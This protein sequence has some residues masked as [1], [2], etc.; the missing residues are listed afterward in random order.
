LANNS[1]SAYFLERVPINTPGFSHYADF[2][3][4]AVILVFTGEIQDITILGFTLTF[5]SF[6]SVAL[7]FGVKESAI[8]NNIFT[9]VNVLVVVCVIG[10]GLW[11]VNL[12]NWQIAPD[13]VPTGFGTGGFAPYGMAGILKGAAICFY[14][15]IGFDVIA[16]AGEEA[17]NPKRSI[18]ISIVVSLTVIF[19]AYFGISSVLTMMLPYFEQNEHSPLPYAFKHYGWHLAEYFITVGAIFGLLASLMGSMFPLPRIIY[20]MASDGLLYSV[21]G[22]VNKR[23]STP[24]YGTFISGVATGTLATFFNLSQLVA[25]MSIGTLLAYSMVAVCVLI[26]RYEVNP[27]DDMEELAPIRDAKLMIRKTFGSSHQKPDNISSSIATGSIIVFCSACILF[28][29]V[30]KFMIAD[31]ASGEWPA[32]LLMTLAVLAGCIS[33]VT[34]SFQPKSTVQLPFQVPLAPWIPCLSILTNVYL[35]MELD[36]MTWIR[37]AVWIGLGL[38]VYFTYGIKNSKEKYREIPHVAESETT[39][40]QNG[41]VT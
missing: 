32:I 29:V 27:H 4:F 41:T 3:A 22:K 18:P 21:M 39:S 10:G 36:L 25:M 28:G 7:A 26:L 17:M 15:F 38:V 6:P 20:A 8:V 16:T 23:F 31:L 12:K 1:I 35:M 34:I 13:Q 30:L 19:F 2:F 33:V 40:L 9:T 24:L 37:F 5:F 14:G 11:W